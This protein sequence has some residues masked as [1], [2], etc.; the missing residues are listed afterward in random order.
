LR[1]AAT[2]AFLNPLRAASRTAHALSG[3]NRCTLVINAN[4]ASYSSLRMVPS[5]RLEMRPE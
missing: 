2:A 3:E 1:T 5:P 4:A